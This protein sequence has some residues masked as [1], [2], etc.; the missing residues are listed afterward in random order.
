MS[1]NINLETIDKSNPPLCACGKC[2][3]HVT[4]NKR[5]RKWNKYIR[6]HQIHQFN[7]SDKGKEHHKRLIPTPERRE[8]S[9]KRMIAYNNSDEGRKNREQFIALTKTEERRKYSSDH[10]K[11]FNNSIEGQ[12]HRQRVESDPEIE[13][14]RV[15]ARQRPEYQKRMREIRTNP[16]FLKNLSDKMKERWTNEDYR[17]DVIRKIKEKW[18]DPEYKIKKL[19]SYCQSPNKIEQLIN[20]ITSDKIYFTGDRSWWRKVTILKDGEY[21]EQYKNPDFKIKGQNK[22]I[23]IFGDYWHKGENPDI[24]I[25]AYKESGLACLVIWEKEIKQDIESVL[26]KI[27][28]F[29]GEQSWQ[30][31]LNI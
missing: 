27:A 3:R 6:G 1:D 7:E 10:M 29:V 26:N 19:S 9:R 8:K 23:E 4:I 12:I 13:A 2:N 15:E 24:L 16:V 14:K 21:I 25:S 31:S 20:R 30:M 5:T 18:K 28:K 11:Q 17:E 22:V